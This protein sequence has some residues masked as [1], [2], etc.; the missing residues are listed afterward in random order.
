MDSFLVDGCG[1][2]Y[3]GCKLYAAVWSTADDARST[4]NDAWSAVTVRSTADDARPAANDA[5]PTTRTLWQSADFGKPVQS[6]NGYVPTTT[7][8]SP[9][10]TT[11]PHDLSAGSTAD[12]AVSLIRGYTNNRKGS[13]MNSLKVV[14]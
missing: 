8:K 13:S 2:N 5:W 3:R 12:A 4:A 10:P 6:G 1:R 9:M 11:G 7:S 14:R